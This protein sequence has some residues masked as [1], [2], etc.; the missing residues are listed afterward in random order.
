MFRNSEQF[1]ISAAPHDSNSYGEGSSKPVGLPEFSHERSIDSM[2]WVSTPNEECGLGS[3]QFVDLNIDPRCKQSHDF[4][5]LW[6]MAQ[7]YTN[8]VE[9]QYSPTATRN[10]YTLSMTECI[11]V[12][13]CP[14]APVQELQEHDFLRCIEGAPP[15]VIDQGD[16]DCTLHLGTMLS[17]T[18]RKAKECMRGTSS[19]GALSTSMDDVKTS[20][21]GAVRDNLTRSMVDR[22]ASARLSSLEADQRNRTSEKAKDYS[23]GSSPWS[24]I[25]SGIVYKQ[26]AVQLAPSS[27]TLAPDHLEEVDEC[28][29]SSRTSSNS[30]ESTTKASCAVSECEILP[31]HSRAIEPENYAEAMMPCMQ[32]AGY[33]GLPKRWFHYK[34]CQGGG[35]GSSVHGAGDDNARN[36]TSR[37]LCGNETY[38]SLTAVPSSCLSYQA[39]AF[40]PQVFSGPKASNSKDG[41]NYVIRICAQCKTMRTP[42]WRNGPQG[43]KSLCN[44]CGIRYKKEERRSA[45]VE[46]GK[47]EESDR[48]PRSSLEPTHRRSRLSPFPADAITPWAAPSLDDPRSGIGCD[49]RR[50]RSFLTNGM[51]DMG[52]AGEDRQLSGIKDGDR[53]PGFL[54]VRDKKPKLRND[55]AYRTC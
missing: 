3:R 48:R 10:A 16:V 32:G 11:D 25:C 40:T 34:D 24:S 28:L 17:I 22:A 45:A 14:H 27:S 9:M 1:T 12:Q 5:P 44:A 20:S 38:R 6:A 39:A 43:P 49:N 55:N 54:S 29:S 52:E 36:I 15:T 21:K 23:K 46:D 33:Y 30:S 13:M 51:D 41:S 37:D 53:L 31:L 35:L 7:S 8:A 47:P 50:A 42:L 26:R 18:P 4:S 19:P 2:P